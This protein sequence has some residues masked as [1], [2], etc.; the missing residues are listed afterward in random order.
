[1]I[2][3]IAG[4]F[5][6]PV[7]QPDG[8]SRVV[9]KGPNDGPFNAEPEQEAR[10]V[11]MKLA[12]YVGQSKVEDEQDETEDEHTE[13]DT[14]DGAPIGFDDMPPEDFD[15]DA[16]EAEEPVDLETLTAKE[17]R[18][19]GKEYGLTFKANDKKDAMIAAIIAAQA[20]AIE[21][22]DAEDAPGFDAAEAV[23]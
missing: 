10:L 9:A 12:K 21:D 16:E 11:A 1:M 20:E 22:E 23:L 15:E 6:L 8:K 19:I 5:G 17:L 3:M 4:V 13:C 18:E 7:K 14:D 2:E